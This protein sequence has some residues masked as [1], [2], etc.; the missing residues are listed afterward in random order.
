MLT[1][2][3]YMSRD[4]VTV[5]PDTSVREIAELLVE[6]R[7]GGLPVVDSGRVVG[8]V[9]ESDLLAKAHG[10]DVVSRRPFGRIIGESGATQSVLAK[11]DASTAGEAMSSPA[12]TISPERPVT[13]AAA[14]MAKHRVN[15]LPVVDG[16]QLVGVITRSD[17]VRAYTRTDEELAALIR[18]AVL[19]QTLWQYPARFERN[20]TDGTVHIRGHVERRSTALLVERIPTL[21][22]GVVNVDAQVTWEIDD[23]PAPGA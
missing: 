20:V 22:P 17:V 8:V 14:T 18:D 6:H 23:Q 13:E 4:V 12:V 2:G 5:A 16:D 9:S 21:I 1:V 7:I 11:I 3:D 19:Y 15:R 10:P